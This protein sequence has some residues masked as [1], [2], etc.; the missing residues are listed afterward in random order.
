M[1]TPPPPKKN[2]YI[3][4]IKNR[5]CK[6]PSILAAAHVFFMIMA[7][8]NLITG[9]KYLWKTCKDFFSNFA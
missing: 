1:G 9:H 7:C 5:K 8:I 2:I 4:I 6:F 3:I